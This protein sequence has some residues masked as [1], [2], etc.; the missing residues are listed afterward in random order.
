MKLKELFKNLLLLFVALL[1]FFSCLEI[2]VRIFAPETKRTL[3]FNEVVGPKRIPDIKF[4]E[5]TS[6]F[7]LITHRT[8]SLGF[9]DSEH[10][11]EKEENTY[12]IVF[13]GDS[14]TEA[15]QVP[16]DKT[17]CKILETKLNEIGANKKFEIINLG[18]S[19][20][21]TGQEYLVLKEFGL[22]YNPDLVVLIFYA[23][24]DVFY[25][26]L[27]LY[28]GS[29]E[30]YFD[31]KDGL[32][33]QVHYPQPITHNKLV[34][35]IIKHFQSP[36]FFYKKIQLLKTRIENWKNQLAKEEDMSIDEQL[37]IYNRYYDNNWKKAWQITGALIKE[38]NI[39]SQ[40]NKA[41]LL[42][43]YLPAAIEANPEL[44]KEALDKYPA[45]KNLEWDLEK[46][47]YILKEFS[48]ETNINYLDLLP[49]FREYI[50]ETGEDLYSNHFNYNGH[51][52]TAEL[53]YNFLL[54]NNL[55][56]I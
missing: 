49:S 2:G 45:M 1:A 37:R 6:E 8:N 16:R 22:K 55:I 54:S 21:A 48:Q 28:D 38:I 5:R 33:T 41:D 51:K 26:S 20:Y 9:V 4:K 3:Q 23:R 25:N 19:G 36:R 53:L 10:K 24:N 35:F 18:V 27:S 40:N 43:V 52:L 17:F 15:L 56:K 46:P 50:S 12:R 34:S 47:N 13:L 7:G 14:W 44:W 29:S 31:L 42:V 30:P 11:L 39:N 32:L